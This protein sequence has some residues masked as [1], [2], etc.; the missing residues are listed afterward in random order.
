MRV[1]EKLK[2][3]G[4]TDTA[5]LLER[6][7]KNTI[8]EDLSS[9]GCARF[10]RDTLQAIRKQGTFIQ[11]LDHLQEPS[12]RQIGLF[13]PVPQMLTGKNLRNQVLKSSNSNSGSLVP[14]TGRIPDHSRSSPRSGGRPRPSTVGAMGST[15]EASASV[16]SP[17]L[18][19]STVTG[20]SGSATPHTVSSIG[21]DASSSVTVLPRLRG[22]RSGL[23]HRG[24]MRPS[25]TA[26]APALL[27]PEAAESEFSPSGGFTGRRR[28]S[29][30]SSTWGGSS[31]GPVRERS[32]TIVASRD[33]DEDQQLERDVDRWNGAGKVMTSELRLPQ[34][35][36]FSNEL[37]EHGEAMIREQDALEDKK[38]LYQQI[39]YEGV[40]S[41]MRS[42]VARKIRSRLREEKLHEAQVALD[43]QQTCL[44]IRK[45]IEAMMKTRR[46]LASVNTEAKNVVEPQ[47]EGKRLVGLSLDLFKK[48]KTMDVLALEGESSMEED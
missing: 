37:L 1:L 47:K 43:V 42:H 46:L 11:S 29:G 33:L 32:A 5:E 36:S 10:S 16:L 31:A 26:S 45:N 20:T 7:A 35:S 9:V 40:I 19:P 2:A 3:I 22:A 14:I 34:W 39:R 41:P 44:S 12:Y 21:N 25:T 18:R 13:A 38:K 4:I 30:N 28:D 48:Q 27:T 17:R 8:N 23:A 24:R 15:P 6:V